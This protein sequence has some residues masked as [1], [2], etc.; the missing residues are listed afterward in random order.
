MMTVLM[1]TTTTKTVNACGAISVCQALL[2]VLNAFTLHN[3]TLNWIP[4]SHTEEM[5]ALSC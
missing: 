5:E 3:H 2:Q 4:L 1:E